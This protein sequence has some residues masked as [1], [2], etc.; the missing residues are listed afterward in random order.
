MTKEIFLALTYQSHG[1]SELVFLTQIFKVR[2]CVWK[3]ASHF[4]C[5]IQLWTILGLN[6]GRS[7]ESSFTQIGACKRW[8]SFSL[9][10]RKYL[11]CFCS[12]PKLCSIQYETFSFLLV[13]YHHTYKPIFRK[14][15]MFSS[16]FPWNLLF[17]WFR[18]THCCR[19]TNRGRFP[20][21][22]LIS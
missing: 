22:L 2:R 10:S 16:S 5:H 3:S 7:T 13:I 8:R 21:L 19:G 14:C 18:V 6:A 9:H 4:L 15:F 17:H 11:L 1:K 12:I 20:F